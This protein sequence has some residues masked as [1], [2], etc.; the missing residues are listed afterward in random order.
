MA[1]FGPYIIDINRHIP[2]VVP[3]SQ[4]DNGGSLVFAV[5]NG[6]QPYAL[7]GTALLNGR[8]PSG[9]VFTYNA[10]SVSGH[11]ATFTINEQMTVEAGQVVC[12][13]VHSGAGGIRKGSANFILDIE[14]DPMEDGITTETDLSI[15][16]EAIDA[17]G[18][19]IALERQVQQNTAN[20]GT[21]AQDIATN[22]QGIAT[23]ASGIQTINDTAF[24]QRGVLP[25]GSALNNVRTFGTYGLDA[26]S[27]YTNL[28]ADVTSADGSLMV[29]LDGA[30]G[31]ITQML[32]I[33][34][35]Q[36]FTRRYNGSSWMTWLGGPVTAEPTY[37]NCTPTQ[38]PANLLSKTGNV[39]TFRIYA[40]VTE[41]IPTGSSGQGFIVFP[42]GFRP[43]G[44]VFVQGAATSSPRSFFF[45]SSGQWQVLNTSLAVGEYI[46]VSGSFTV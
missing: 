38:A 42:S 28:P 8:K 4:N 41:A 24:F 10:A 36:T 6:D 27:T 11:L 17:A 26:S 14:R 16:A 34:S 20:I 25:S 7:E 18:S 5:Y 2:L 15:M 23:N 39:V 31:F 33:N 46:R 21:N 9:H 30:S 12:E 19:V 37:T 22:A 3:L 35:S 29:F 43:G 1:T 13:V 40:T 45:T 44:S 32:V